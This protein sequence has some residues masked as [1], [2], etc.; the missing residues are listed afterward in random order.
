[1]HQLRASH[2]PSQRRWWPRPSPWAGG[3]L[4]H[5]AGHEPA[6][7]LH[8]PRPAG[9]L[10]LQ[11]ARTPPSRQP[12]RS[13]RRWRAT[14]ARPESYSEKKTKLMLRVQTSPTQRC[15]VCVG[16]TRDAKDVTPGDAHPSQSSYCKKIHVQSKPVHTIHS[17]RK[18][19]SEHAAHAMLPAHTQRPPSTPKGDGLF[20]PSPPQA[21]LLFA[22]RRARA[23]SATG[24]R[25]G[26]VT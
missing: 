1:M 18:R 11:R 2:R 15:G 26:R 14:A 12:Q 4:Q 7:L 25:N 5:G 23:P 3:W 24:R 22:T 19:K 16:C 9:A 21:P 17:A 8:S 20:I 6:L 13:P 10:A